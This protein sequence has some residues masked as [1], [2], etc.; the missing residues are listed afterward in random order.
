MVDTSTGVGIISHLHAFTVTVRACKLRACDQACE[1]MAILEDI[2]V[3]AVTRG[4]YEDFLSTQPPLVQEQRVTRAVL[5]LMSS[6]LV[7]RP[8][9]NADSLNADQKSQRKEHTQ[10]SA[11][12]RMTCDS[13]TMSYLLSVNLSLCTANLRSALNM[14]PRQQ[15]EGQPP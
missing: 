11:R 9:A 6:C 1:D 15:S 5:S 13:G 3:W 7:P 4:C 2:Q 12:V 10:I 14:S 8:G